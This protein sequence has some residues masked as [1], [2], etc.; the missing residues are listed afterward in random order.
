[1]QTRLGE[2]LDAVKLFFSSSRYELLDW[3]KC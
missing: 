1:M 3:Y 2:D